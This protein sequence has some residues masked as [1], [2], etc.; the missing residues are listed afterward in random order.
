MKSDDAKSRM[1]GGYL[2]F[3]HI[4]TPV[5]HEMIDNLYDMCDQLKVIS[6]FKPD[7]FRVAD[8]VDSK[9]SKRIPYAERSE[10]GTGIDLIDTALD[11][12]EI[13]SQFID[14]T[15]LGAGLKAWKMLTD[16]YQKYKAVSEEEQAR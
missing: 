13:A 2:D 5:E 4:R 12:S 7:D 16:I 9:R 1:V 15:Y 3:G 10:T 8:Y 6:N 14:L 11:I